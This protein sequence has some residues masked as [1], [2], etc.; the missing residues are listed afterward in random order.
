VHANSLESFNAF[1]NVDRFKAIVLV[2]QPVSRKSR[3]RPTRELIAS[4]YVDMLAWSHDCSLWGDDVDWANPARYDRKIRDDQDVM[5]TW[6]AEETLERFFAFV[7]F[8]ALT[9]MDDHEI[10]R[11]LIVHI[12]TAQSGERMFSLHENA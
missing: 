5:T 7:K 1:E 4:D 3:E 6:H 11:C 2:E 12:A 8:S 9:D 10:N